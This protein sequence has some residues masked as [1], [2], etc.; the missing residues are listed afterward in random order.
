M[1]FYLSKIAFFLIR[2]ANF[3]WFLVLVGL[4]LVLLGRRR[5]GA[6][7]LVIGIGIQ[8]LFAFTPLPNWL[9][10][11]LEQR[12]ASPDLST[13]TVDGVIILGGAVEED[14][15]QL[16]GLPSLNEAAERL[17]AASGLARQYPEAKIVFTGG[18]AALFGAVG[19]EADAA[20]KSL[21]ELGLPLERIILEDQS[22]NTFENA[23]LTY[24]LVKPQPE[25][26]WLLV[27]SAFHMP[28][29]MG[30][31]RKVGWDS[32]VAYPVDFR[33]SG[34]RDLSRA[35]WTVSEGGMRTDVAVKEW[36][37][38]LAYRVLGR[39]NALFP[40]P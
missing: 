17:T 4:V 25:E 24:D 13:M 26:T 32:I 29:S 31:F 30:V 28:R 23:V 15:A 39:T 12:F 22:R 19:T 1:L 2:P 16:R 21:I 6:F 37:G 35:F 8:G 10:Y 33:T 11:P 7:L 27:T 34:P 18:S 3:A 9:I 38:L 14:V 36:I 40:A 20:A 5:L